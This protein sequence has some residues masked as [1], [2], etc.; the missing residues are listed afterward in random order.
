MHPDDAGAIGV[1]DGENVIVDSSAGSIRV[2]AEVTPNITR[3]AVSVVHGVETANVN[4]LMDATDLD[5]LT[6]MARLAAVAVSVRPA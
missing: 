6:G 3:G 1:V 5:P 4:E 2:R